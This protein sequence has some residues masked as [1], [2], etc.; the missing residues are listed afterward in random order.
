MFS[1]VLQNLLANKFLAKN[2]LFPMYT[3]KVIYFIGTTL[4]GA[5]KQLFAT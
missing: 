5:A 3:Y 4:K 2:D 1:L